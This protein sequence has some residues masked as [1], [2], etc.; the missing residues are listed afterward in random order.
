MLFSNQVF[1]VAVSIY[2]LIY[3][4]REIKKLC[5]VV[6]ELTII[7]RELNKEVYKDD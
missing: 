2:L 5:E 7:V 4:N 3:F 6:T 1:P